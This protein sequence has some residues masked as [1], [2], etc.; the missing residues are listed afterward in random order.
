MNTH[1]DKHPDFQLTFEIAIIEHLGLNL[2]S[3]VHSAISE[4]V[5]NAYDAE[6]TEVN[7]MI[8]LGVPL[9]LEGQQITVEDNGHGMTY[10]E[11]RDKFL[12]IGRN[13]RR[14]S[15]KSKHNLRKV[16]GKKGIGKLAGF[17][18]AD[19]LHITT[20]A[21][22]KNTEFIL[23]LDEIR[24]A[25]PEKSDNAPSD[26]SNNGANQVNKLESRKVE[27]PGTTKNDLAE[28][29]DATP[30]KSSSESSSE[31]S[32]N[33]DDGTTRVYKPELRKVEE[34]GT[35]KQ[36]TTVVLSKIRQLDAIDV[37]DF[38]HRLSRKFA[39]FGDDFRVTLIDANSGDEYRVE[40]YHVPTQFRFPDDGWGTEYISTITMGR[41]EVK[42]WIGFTQATIKN[43]SLKGI[44][45]IANGKSVQ[46]PFLFQ[47]S[48]GVEGQFGIQYMTGEVI[49]DWLDEGAVDVIASDRSSVRWSNPDAARLIDWGKQKIKDCL[50]EWA[51][52]RSQR[53]LLDISENSPEIQRE[54]ESYSGSAR[55]ELEQV[56]ERV[57]AI[58]SH[59]SQERSKE[60]IGSIVTAYRHD[61]VRQV[62]V[63]VIEGYGGVDLFGEALAEWDL[64][65]AVL[66][67]QEL[68]VKLTALYTLKVLVLG[69][70]TEV[71][72]KSG[73]L[74]LHEHLARHPW[75]IDPMFSD[76][77]HEMSVEKF[78]LE[79]YGKEPDGQK[80]RFDFVLL[81]DKSPR[82]R[83]IEIKSAKDPIDIRGLTKLMSYHGRIKNEE[84]RRGNQNFK[85]IVIH[86][87]KAAGDAEH[88]LG[89]IM[90][91]S[92][93]E[94]YQWEELVTRNENIYK[95][96]MRYVRRKNPNDPRVVEL[97][98]E[99]EKRYEK[100]GI[101]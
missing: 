63:K 42:Y 18:I 56:V 89:T 28:I 76:M 101:G 14:S 79:R 27:Q 66:T 46:E 91:N 52:L 58:I 59:V 43:D 81:H 97:E 100:L 32:D 11:C 85:S 49:A 4:L 24:N 93:Y 65:D 3:E 15:S 29:G 30:Q 87:G 75:L 16:I 40:K 84:L 55:T 57:T 82:I 69:R 33:S 72:S 26:N 51:K 71:K 9:G 94:I 1:N 73:N 78:M 34:P 50:K 38:L 13:R 60:V 44:T 96:Q 99:M 86:N 83:L 23:N 90:G 37:K 7:I 74:S 61:H 68:S 21:N 67:F 20:A 10:A 22:F 39:I 54:I 19:Q 41:Q 45:V 31:S 5:A 98:K 12:R 2:Y 62:L 80:D 36:G 35:I 92:E 64:I 53:T 95:E 8:P 48:G 25:K 88:I 6:A 70:A 17:G 47:L 77:D